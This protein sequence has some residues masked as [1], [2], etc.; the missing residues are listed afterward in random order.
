MPPTKIKIGITPILY[1]IISNKCYTKSRQNFTQQRVCG[2]G[3]FAPSP[4]L[5][6][7][8]GR[9]QLRKHAKRYMKNWAVLKKNV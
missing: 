6:Q 7:P 8:F 9:W 4:K 3:A 1:L 2:S 5:P